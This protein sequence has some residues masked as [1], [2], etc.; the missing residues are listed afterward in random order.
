MS[1]FDETDLNKLMKL[2]RIDCSEQEKQKLISSLSRVVS[3][4]NLLSEVDTE[5]V[6]PCNHILETLANVTREDEVG[7][8]LSR[9]TFLANAPSHVG[10]MV[11][12]P[13]VIKTNPS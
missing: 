11:K 1:H 6:A 5:G 10:G 8:T 9:E 13:T 2:S 7:P 3:Y 4:I 12:V